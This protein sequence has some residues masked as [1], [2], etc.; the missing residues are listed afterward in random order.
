MKSD[1]N[2]SKKSIPINTSN[3]FGRRR[4]YDDAELDESPPS[5]YRQKDIRM[6][7]GSDYEI[8]VLS[9]AKIPKRK[10][11]TGS[12]RRVSLGVASSSRLNAYGI[13]DS[14][15]AVQPV[16]RTR[17]RGD[18]MDRIR[19]WV[20]KR[21]LNKKELARKETDVALVNGRRKINF[22]EPK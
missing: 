3:S 2:L 22:Y 4:Q 5:I 9:H 1:P 19:V 20:R 8:D 13:S 17:D 14:A 16:T 18:T 11:V 10:S 21:P 12:P 7:G 6:D 15:L